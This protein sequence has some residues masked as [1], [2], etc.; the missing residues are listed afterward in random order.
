M[1]FDSEVAQLV[2]I[3]NE[4]R[5]YLRLGCDPPLGEHYF[6]VWCDQASNGEINHHSLETRLITLGSKPIV[7]L[8]FCLVELIKLQ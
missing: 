2:V 4:L 8:L 1:G 7:L 5:S 3:I 6:V